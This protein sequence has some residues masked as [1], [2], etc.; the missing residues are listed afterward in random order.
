MNCFTAQQSPQ[1]RKCPS[2]KWFTPTLRQC[3]QQPTG[4]LAAAQVA[5]ARP[6]SVAIGLTPPGHAHG[7]RMR[8]LRPLD[9]AGTA[10]LRHAATLVVPPLAD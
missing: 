9:R 8:L 6:R 10:C 1:V 7:L 5:L 4:D 3:V 2:L